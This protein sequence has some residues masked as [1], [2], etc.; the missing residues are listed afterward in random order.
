VNW[1]C[2][3]IAFGSAEYRAALVLR[4]EVLRKPLGLPVRPED[5]AGEEE[6]FHLGC[7]EGERLVGTLILKPVDETTVKMRQVAIA[8]ETQG[9][10]AGSD[11]VK[12]AE[13][14]ARA[15]GFRTITAHV[16][17]P[18]LHF[19]I[20]RGYGLRSERFIE[21]TIPHYAVAKEIGD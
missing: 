17:E 21:V 2:R 4:E 14:F 11:L 3:K 15:K 1:T 5:V 6:S 13:E 19:Y 8:P 12:F 9:K 20:R 7:F 10:G 16:R 18:V